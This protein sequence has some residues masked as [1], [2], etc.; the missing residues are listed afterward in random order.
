MPPHFRVKELRHF[1]RYPTQVEAHT[2]FHRRH[3]QFC[4]HGVYMHYLGKLSSAIWI[5]FLLVANRLKLGLRRTKQ[6]EA[7]P[8]LKE[9]YRKL[10]KNLPAEQ[11]E[12][13]MMSIAAHHYAASATKPRRASLT[14]RPA[15]SE[16]SGFCS[17]LR[18]PTRTRRL[19]GLFPRRRCRSFA[20]ASV[21]DSHAY[22][23]LITARG[24]HRLIGAFQSTRRNH[25]KRES[26]RHAS[27]CKTWRS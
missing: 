1:P 18:A 6:L 8:E 2:V 20:A 4:G 26:K 23:G 17:G 21:R 10:V 11:Q 27:A 12:R 9:A 5:Y 16:N 7:N 22:T 15:K 24:K 19:R 25:R 14:K 3:I 13:V